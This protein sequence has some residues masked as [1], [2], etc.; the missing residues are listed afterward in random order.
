ELRY[1]DEGLQQTKTVVVWNP[2]N[3]GAGNG[4]TSRPHQIISFGSEGND[5][6]TGN[7]IATL[8]D[9]LYGGG[10]IDTV[11]GLAG[12]DY[13]EGNDG[14][15]LLDGGT[16]V[17]TL[18]GGGGDDTLIGGEGHDLLLGGS[19]NDKYYFEVNFGLDITR[20]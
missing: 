8:G 10:G 19:G 16:G 9:H 14:S 3:N 12:D 17:D 7:S 5:T 13:L 11:N 18:L 2:A 4:L 1:F 6:I 15:D 20:V